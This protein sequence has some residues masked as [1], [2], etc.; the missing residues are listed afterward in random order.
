[1]MWED[2]GRMTC[3][4]KVGRRVGRGLEGPWEGRT[5]REKSREE[6]GDWGRWKFARRKS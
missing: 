4:E 5:Q 2:E 3:E 6:R 1:L